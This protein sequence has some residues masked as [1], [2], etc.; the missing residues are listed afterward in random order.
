MFR[1]VECHDPFLEVLACIIL[2]GI[3]M[4]QINGVCGVTSSPS[5]DYNYWC[6]TFL[7][8]SVPFE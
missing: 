6:A 3:L 7:A 1:F 8:S 2:R 4:L 5:R